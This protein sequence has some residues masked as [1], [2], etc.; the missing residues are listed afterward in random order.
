VVADYSAIMGLAAIVVVFV[1]TPAVGLEPLVMVQTQTAMLM[2]QP[3]PLVAVMA[4]VRE[5]QESHAVIA[6]QTAAYAK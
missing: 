2:A 1:T 3:P 5:A 4:L 6:K